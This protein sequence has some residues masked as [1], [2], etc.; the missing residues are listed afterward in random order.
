MRRRI[1]EP[2]EDFV[3]VMRWPRSKR[4]TSTC[5][6]EVYTLTIGFRMRMRRYTKIIK[7]VGWWGHAPGSSASALAGVFRRSRNPRSTRSI[8]FLRLLTVLSLDEWGKGWRLWTIGTDMFG[9]RWNIVLW[10][11]PN[12][13][14][15]VDSFR[16]SIN[17]ADVS[18]LLTRIEG[19]QPFS[20]DCS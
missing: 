5:G 19:Q 17:W 13:C 3:N 18:C 2:P 12:S 9:M 20:I 6:R 10:K 16:V 1:P 8:T 11:W 7:R 4:V 15:Q 14:W